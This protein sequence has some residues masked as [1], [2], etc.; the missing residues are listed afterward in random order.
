MTKNKQEPGDDAKSPQTVRNPPLTV[1][2][3]VWSR[4]TPEHL[5]CCGLDRHTCNSGSSGPHGMRLGNMRGASRDTLCSTRGDAFFYCYSETLLSP[6]D[7]M[8]R[9]PLR[10]VMNALHKPIQLQTLSPRRTQVPQCKSSEDPGWIL[11]L[12]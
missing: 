9:S 11:L 6:A 1:D 7:Y 4:S 8:P 10:N 3:P 5:Y 12:A 2:P